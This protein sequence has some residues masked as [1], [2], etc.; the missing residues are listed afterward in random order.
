MRKDFDRKISQSKMFFVRC[1]AAKHGKLF[2][3]LSKTSE[4]RARSCPC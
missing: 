3:L 4:D 2:R 1:G